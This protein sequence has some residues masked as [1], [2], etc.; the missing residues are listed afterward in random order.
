[1]IATIMPMRTKMTIATCIQ[2]Q[3]GDIERNPSD[4][5]LSTSPRGTGRLYGVDMVPSPLRTVVALLLAVASL[6][7][8]APGGRAAPVQGGINLPGV[9]AS[10]SPAEAD[11]EIAFAKSLR[12]KVVRIDVRWASL[13]PAGA[14][15]DPRRLAYLDRV[16]QDAAN[17]GIRVSATVAG[18]PCW[19]SSAPGFELS[20]CQ[21]GRESAANAWPPSNPSDYAAFVAFLAGRYGARLAAI[22]IWNEPDQSNEDYF[23][24]PSKPQRYAAVLR[25][26]YPAIKRADPA[27][28]VLAG[29]LVGS[30]GVF[31]RA[32]YAAGIK[33]Y[34][35][36]L[37]VH[38]YNLTLASLRAIHEVQIANG[39]TR[40]LWLDEFG[41]TSCWPGH[42]I[43]Q[44]QGCVTQQ[45]QATNLRNIFRSFR[46]F[47][48]VATAIAYKLQDSPSESFGMLTGGGARK[49]SFEA[50]VGALRSPFGAISPVTLSLRRRGRSVVASGSGP[51][52][53]FMQLEAFRGGVL[54]FRALFTLDRF[55][56]YSIVLPSVLGTRGLKVRVFQY[57]AG[58]R[59][60][61]NRS[62]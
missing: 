18:T 16:V 21:P 26:A 23:A 61:A 1:M 49:P 6:L 12:V 13:E 53:D 57:W 56:H 3:V 8:M 14:Q 39:D 42:R 20:T 50:L 29:S 5:R 17:A 19:A 48:Y 25:A 7:V 41:W 11:R 36:G 62:I 55:N 28:P 15:I 32:L 24:G 10:S 46:H 44:E 34:Y 30:N 35:D 37:S 33:G 47:P 60:A 51:V 40:P 45:V 54:R 9:G 43:Q 52:A 27:V 38:Y 59:G 2:I 4:R 31:L 22:E 58:A